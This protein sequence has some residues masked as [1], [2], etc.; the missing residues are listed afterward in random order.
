[1]AHQRAYQASSAEQADEHERKVTN[2]DEICIF[3]RPFLSCR[4]FV[5]LWDSRTKQQSLLFRTEKLLIR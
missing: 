5:C 1:M 3:L 2:V 4:P